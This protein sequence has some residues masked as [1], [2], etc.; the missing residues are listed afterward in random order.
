LRQVPNR[1][2]KEFFD[3]KQQL[4]EVP[5]AT[6]K[7]TDVG[8]VYAAW[9]ALPA[10]DRREIEGAFQAVHEM[11]CEEG[12]RTLVEE[13][14]FHDIDLGAVLD[15]L[16]SHYHKAMFTYLHHER[17]F[18]VASCFFS[19]DTLP[20]RYWVRRNG[21]SHKQ[22]ATSAAAMKLL[23]GGL[24]DYYR[25]SQGRGHRCTVETYLRGGHQH[26]FFAYPDDY[27]D[28]YIGHD[29]Q[30]Q[31]V[32]RPQKRAFENVFVFDSDAGALDLYAQGD[33]GVKSRLAYIFSQV[34]LSENPPPP[35]PGDHPYELN[36][37]RS[38]D[39]RFPTDAGDGIE[40]V[41]ITKL[42]LSLGGSRRRIVLE[43]DPDGGVHD[44]HDMVDEYF[45]KSRLSLAAWNVTSAHFQIT[46]LC[47]EGHRPKSMLF[48]VSFPNSSN[49]KNLSEERRLLAEKYLKRWGI[50][51]G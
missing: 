12:V 29:D 42:R 31:F 32:R 38:R 36:G 39:C 43:A 45:D 16:D 26:Y 5:W 3:R 6:L 9:Q 15:P 23:A 11:A 48:S 17:V 7:E 50:A 19:A 22:P 30:G 35:A 18:R 46:F 24:S 20:A 44:V 47:V 1:L 10:G 14:R 13:G 8:L 41:R 49:Y 37:L 51:R 4:N 25:E 34:I 2:L 28:T 27:T 21:F 40:E 33:Q